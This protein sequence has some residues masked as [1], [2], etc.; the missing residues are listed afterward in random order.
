[1]HIS[2]MLVFWSLIFLFGIVWCWQ[3]ISCFQ[4][5]A[6]LPYMSIKT[7]IPAFQCWEPFKH[8]FSCLFF[9]HIGVSCNHI[10]YAYLNHFFHRTMKSI[11]T[12]FKAILAIFLIFVSVRRGHWP[13]SDPRDCNTAGRLYQSGFGAGQGSEFSIMLPTR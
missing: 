7:C 5:L 2:I 12:V 4:L 8:A 9:T 11:F 6:S 13:V 10:R 1:M 3:S